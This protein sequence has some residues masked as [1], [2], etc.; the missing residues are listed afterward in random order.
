MWQLPTHACQ[1][2]CGINLALAVPF[3]SWHH[4][5]LLASMSSFVVFAAGFGLSQTRDVAP[6]PAVLMC[7]AHWHVGVD[8]P[9]TQRLWM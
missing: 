1:H 2:A 5:I 8:H 6:N 3:L 4:N 9:T 7:L